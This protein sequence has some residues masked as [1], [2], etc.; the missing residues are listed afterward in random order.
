MVGSLNHQLPTKSAGARS[1]FSDTSRHNR[2]AA[3]VEEM[4]KAKNR[5]K[6]CASADFSCQSPGARSC[7]SCELPLQR[8]QRSAAR[9]QATAWRRPEPSSPRSA[10]RTAASGAAPVCMSPPWRGNAHYGP[11]ATSF[12][13]K[14]RKGPQANP[15]EPSLFD[16]ATAA[17]AKAN[18]R[19]GKRTCCKLGKKCHQTKPDASGII[20]QG[21]AS[22]KYSS[23]H[24]EA[25]SETAN[26]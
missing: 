17:L 8:L 7:V 11:F 10:P 25:H 3:C 24:V 14:K 20:H 1:G 16:M 9:L 5:R 13:T 15:T 23:L 22:K 19:H 6:T 26:S 18:A 21:A 12:Y 4:R 2:F